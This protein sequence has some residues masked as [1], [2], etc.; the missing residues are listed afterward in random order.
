MNKLLPLRPLLVLS[1]VAFLGATALGCAADSGPEDDDTAALDATPET[2]GETDDVLEGD[3][4]VA[5]DEGTGDESIGTTTE[6]LTGAVKK[7]ECSVHVM[8]PRIGSTGVSA[9]SNAY[10]YCKKARKTTLSFMMRTKGILGWQTNWRFD[11]NVPDNGHYDLGGRQVSLG[12]VSEI[13]VE[14]KICWTSTIRHCR[15]D[16]ATLKYLN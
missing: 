13:Y 9:A 12:A 6:A 8:K 5:V 10:G 1:T 16:S 3:D 14:A 15:S 4:A 11:K 2:T 7:G